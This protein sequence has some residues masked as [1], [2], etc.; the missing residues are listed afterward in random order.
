M[1]KI[2]LTIMLI[3]GLVI[4]TLLPQTNALAA[5][6][7]PGFS[8]NIVKN[9]FQSQDIGYFDLTGLKAGDK[10]T[11][12][13]DVSN[14]SAEAVT[15][16]VITSNAL[17]NQNLIIDYSGQVSE[18]QKVDGLHFSDLA[19]PR[20][21]VIHLA[22]HSK[23]LVTIHLT[24]P[25]VTFDGQIM[26]GIYLKKHDTT[27]K[28]AGIHNTFSYANTVIIRQGNQDIKAQPKVSDASYKAKNNVSTV[29]AKVTNSEQAYLSNAKVTQFVTDESGKTIK[30]E[31]SDYRAFAPRT[32][33]PI[34]VQMDILLVPG[35]YYLHLKVEDGA[36]VI[37]S[38]TPFTIN[39]TAAVVTGIATINNTLWLFLGMIM[40]FLLI[41]LFLLWFF[42]WKRRKKDEDEE[43]N[44]ENKSEKNE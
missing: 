14:L 34:N 7:Q 8:V 15:F 20:Q 43:D 19:K 44:N 11:L 27:S 9:P 35:T 10:T 30:S 23:T 22:A 28:T 38:K 16:D 32:T 37:E 24:M 6:N 2:I 1:K 12:Q 25:N 26:G 36:R 3:F 42:L 33:T 4:T 41:I 13:L 29:T 21:A 40:F 39:A 18:G 5:S 17:T 31:S